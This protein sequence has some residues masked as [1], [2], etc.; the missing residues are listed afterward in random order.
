MENYAKQ[1]SGIATVGKRKHKVNPIIARIFY[2][3][4]YLLRPVLICAI[5]PSS[6]T[7]EIF[8]HL[9]PPAIVTS[10]D[11]IAVHSHLCPLHFL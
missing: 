4:P 2:P 1:L 8:H 9:V 11:L 10:P 6:S 5:L 7:V 3:S